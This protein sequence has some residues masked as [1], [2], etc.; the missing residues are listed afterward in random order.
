[1]GLYLA[2]EIMRS[3]SGD[4]NVSSTPGRGSTFTLSVPLRSVQSAQKSGP[5]AEGA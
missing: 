4:I 1:L 2:R 3:H 5:A